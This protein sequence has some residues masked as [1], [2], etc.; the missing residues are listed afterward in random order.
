VARLPRLTVAGLPHHVIVRGVDGRTVF[1][2]DA[3]RQRYYDTLREVAAQAAMDVHAYVLM[4]RHVHLVA[5]PQRAGD[6]GRAIQALARRYVRGF[7]DRHRR[8]GA[9][10]A[11]RYR[12][13]VVDPDRYLLPCMRFVELI[14]VRSGACVQP[15]DYRWSSHR[16][17][18]GLA[19]DPLVTDHSLYWALGN[20]PF[21]RQAAYMALFDHPPPEGEIDEIVRATEGGWLLGSP[22]VLGRHAASRR[23]LALRPGR[24]RRRTA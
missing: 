1:A 15:A 17:H 7:N 12:S 13:T 20:T 9:L 11:G 6:L 3:D 24:P 18:V 4:P 8:T 10:F 5:T 16:H 14:P 23:P 19:A 21:D 2:D 22:T